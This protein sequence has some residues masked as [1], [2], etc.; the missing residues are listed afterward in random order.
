MTVNFVT[1]TAVVDLAATR[2][3]DLAAVRIIMDG[4]LVTLPTRFSEDKFKINMKNSQ[5]Y[6]A[7][8]Q[9]LSFLINSK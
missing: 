8:V 5:K 3:V 7:F 1:M 2:M 9:F 6:I 4:L